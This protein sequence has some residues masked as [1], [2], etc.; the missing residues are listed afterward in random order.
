MIAERLEA[1]FT[2]DTAMMLQG[3]GIQGVLLQSQD[4]IAMGPE[5]L[6]SCVTALESAANQMLHSMHV[7]S[8]RDLEMFAPR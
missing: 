3:V 7:N 6:I 1:P 4:M 8:Q 5:Y 2:V